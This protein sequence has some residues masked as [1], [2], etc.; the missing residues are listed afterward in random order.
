MKRGTVEYGF[1]KDLKY[2]QVIMELLLQLIQA[3]AQK[4]VEY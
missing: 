2:Y 3:I 1:M 4:E